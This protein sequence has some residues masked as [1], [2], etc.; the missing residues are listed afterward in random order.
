L[1]R[2]LIDFARRTPPGERGRQALDMMRAGLRLK[3]AA[4]RA[5]YPQA[6]DEDIERRFLE[7]LAGDGGS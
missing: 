2:D 4:L 6:T 3:R 5:R 1:D 7:W